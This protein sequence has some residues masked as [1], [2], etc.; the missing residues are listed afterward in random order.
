M[1]LSRK[2]SG[3]KASVADAAQARDSNR[4]RSLKERFARGSVGDSE[5]LQRILALPRR[6]KP[7]PEE[8]QAIVHEMT[9]QLKT[10]RGTQT[11]RDHQAWVLKEFPQVGG[12]IAALCTGA[13]KTLIGM[14]MP[15]CFPRITKPDGT[16]RPLRAVLFIPPD[17]RAQFKHDWEVYGK[18][19]KLPNLAGSKGVLGRFDPELPTLHVVAYSELSHAK[20][21]ALLN[22]IQPDL[23]MGDEIS[24]LRNSSSSRTF[25]F[26]S[27]IASNADAHFCGWDASIIADGISDIWHLLAIALDEGS[28]VPTSEEELKKWAA[29]IDPS[30]SEGYFMPGEL[31]KLCNPGEPVRSGFRRRLVET[32]GVIATEENMLGIPLLFEQRIPPATPPEIVKCLKDLRRKPADG[33]WKRP[34]GEELT[35]ATEVVACARQLAEGFYLRWR[36]PHG[37]PEALIDEWFQKRQDWNRELRALLTS[38][39]VHMDSPLLCKN[40]A[41]RWFDGGCTGCK[42]GPREEHE[43][44]CKD[45][46]SHPLWPAYTFTS[47]RAIEKTVYHETQAVWVSDWLLED[48]AVWAR[49]APGIV[50]VDHPEFGHRLEK[51]TGFR[52]YGGGDAANEDI[53]TV[54]GSESIICSMNANKRGKNLQMFNRNLITAFPASNE[55]I[56]QVVGRSYRTMQLA[57]EVRVDYYLHTRELEKAFDVAKTRATFVHGVMGTDQKLCFG[58]FKEVASGP[59]S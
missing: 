3:A 6:E 23:V 25:R 14:L 11:L 4:P 26:L 27:Y 46:E 12:G 16:T 1:G 19:W 51:M 18:H 57:P 42:R 39:R 37:E 33:G 38:P 31:E 45:V 7:G 52:Y 55:M 43:S 53:I 59:V 20:S 47:W 24:N 15:M 50:W 22:Q 36:F 49:E 9:F 10:P 34:D 29:A 17:L 21:T 5:D 28:P 58:K 48:A 56:E 2:K 54:D 8:M 35:Q 41:A 40:A 30:V 32:A 13:G 44:H